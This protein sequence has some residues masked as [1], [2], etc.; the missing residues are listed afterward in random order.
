MEIEW[1]LCHR[2]RHCFFAAERWNFKRYVSPVK[3]AIQ[4]AFNSLQLLGGTTIPV[5]K[6][7]KV[8]VAGVI[9][10]SISFRR[11]A[12]SNSFLPPRRERNSPRAE[13]NGC[14]FNLRRYGTTRSVRSIFHA[15]LCGSRSGSPSE[16][17]SRINAISISH[18]TFDPIR[19]GWRA[20]CVVSI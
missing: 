11:R 3:I 20:S 12:S 15:F 14:S 8:P 1:S 7:Q 10:T 2:S 4:S 19:G 5:R 13:E 9:G 6:Y 16:T 17:D 18:E